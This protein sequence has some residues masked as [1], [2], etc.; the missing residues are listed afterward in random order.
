MMGFAL[1]LG[2]ISLALFALT[3]PGVGSATNRWPSSRN[4]ARKCRR[5]AG[6]T[7]TATPTPMEMG[8]MSLGAAVTNTRVSERLWL[9]VVGGK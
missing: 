2:I 4:N 9:V 8:S 6:R 1:V 7:Q 3:G 5:W